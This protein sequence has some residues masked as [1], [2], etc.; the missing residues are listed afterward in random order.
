MFSGAMSF[1][2][3]YIG[4]M[5]FEAMSFTAMAFGHA[6]LRPDLCQVLASPCLVTH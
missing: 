6:T 3:M 5:S 1:G 2:A 4:D